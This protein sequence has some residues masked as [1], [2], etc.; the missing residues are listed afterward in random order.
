MKNTYIKCPKC[1]LNFIQKKDKVC[2]M[3]RQEMQA[4]HVVGDEISRV[5]LC[6]ICKINYITEDEN[7][8]NTCI[9]E[10]DLSEEELDKLYG[11]AEEVADEE[12]SADDETADDLGILGMQ[13][14]EEPEDEI[15]E[16]E[17]TDPLDDFDDSLDDE[18]LEDDDPDDIDLDDEDDFDEEKF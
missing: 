8:C 15:E 14:E 4:I 6:P 16:E 13:I 3:C 10:S 18:D 11:G 7:V 5:G 1:E 12:S 9:S 2:P 17:S